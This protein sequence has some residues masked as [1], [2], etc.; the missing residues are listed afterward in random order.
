M[1]IV[2]GLLSST[3]LLYK[4]FENL[5]GSFL[6]MVALFFF[7]SFI[8]TILD[9]LK[10]TFVIT[11]VGG[12]AQVIPYLTVYAVL[13]SSL[14]FLL[15]YSHATNI[16]SRPAVFNSIIFVFMAFF[17]LFGLVLY[18]NHQALHLHHL[19]DTLNATLPSGLAGAVGMIQNWTFTIFFCM[20]ELWG[21]VCLSLLFWG[22]ANDTTNIDDAS[23]LYPL[24]GLGA[25]MAQAMAGIALKLFS[26]PGANQSTFNAEVQSVM[27]LVMA[28]SVVV[29]G[30]HAY[31]IKQNKKAK[32]AAA[33]QKAA[34]TAAAAGAQAAAGAERAAGA[35]LLDRLEAESQAASSN[36]TAGSSSPSPS[37]SPSP[38]IGT[39][40]SST[41]MGITAQDGAGRSLQAQA[42]HS[43]ASSSTSS[44]S[45]SSSSR[46]QDSASSASSSASSRASGSQG[47]STSAPAAAGASKA[48][49]SSSKKKKKKNKPQLSE[50][51]RILLSSVEIRCLAVMS[52]AQ[53][54]CTSLMEFAWKCHIKILYPSPSDFTA[55]L[56]DVATWTGVVTGS[57]MV[58]SPLL[59]DKLGWR[60]VAAATPQ[61]LTYGGGVFFAM[62]IA[63]Q[64]V[65]GQ[66]TSATALSLALLNVLV[67][68][69]ALLYVFSKGAKFS[70]FKPAEEMVYIGM[71]EEGR[72]KGKAAIDV[73]GAQTGKSAGS[74]LQQALL[75]LSAG[76]IH[77]IL[78]VMA[79]MFFMMCRSWIKSVNTLADHHDF[80]R[81][82]SV[83]G[84]ASA[85]YDEDLSPGEEGEG[86]G[87]SR[88]SSPSSSPSSP[89][90]SQQEQQPAIV[91]AM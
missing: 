6:P 11:A 55:F 84:S 81:H 75:I 62:C 83:P 18:P 73:V 59:F 70:L 12:G 7:L 63:Y 1:P 47:A 17:A 22:L 91:P 26:R 33:E 65:Y 69:G 20:A 14:I 8:N 21:D 29:L 68:G 74:V 24:F 88:S 5:W 56:G 42:T 48:P 80:S 87:G 35:A 28:F 13:P 9:S 86:G 79:I 44:S 38:S 2:G 71:D 39:S 27:G 41:S 45:S 77:N 85:S 57:L 32:A 61:I 16:M 58:L 50:V 37:R 43:A 60:P 4:R 15:A 30:I 23:T 64:F 40:P 10:D 36:G 66:A 72:T 49:S 53:G 31:I 34:A 3:Y 90:S 19:A 25:N 52:I 54:L 78:P 46:Q 51:W 67:V 82:F 89:S 76:S